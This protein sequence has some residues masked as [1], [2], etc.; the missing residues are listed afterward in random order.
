MTGF[1]TRPK[2]MILVPM[3]KSIG[4]NAD[5]TLGRNVAHDQALPIQTTLADGP[6]ELLV[7]RAAGKHLAI[8]PGDEPAPI[9]A[10]EL[11]VRDGFHR[12]SPSHLLEGLSPRV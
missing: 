12:D 4:I 9:S 1:V 11:G 10:L 6:Q 5:G 3:G 8:L 2:E 7:G